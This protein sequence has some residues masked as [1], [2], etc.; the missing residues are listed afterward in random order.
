MNYSNV[1]LKDKGD[2][3][4]EVLSLFPK[5]NVLGTYEKPLLDKSKI[6]ILSVKYSKIGLKTL[7]DYPNLKTIITRSHGVDNINRDLTQKRNIKI[8]KTNP[9]TNNC[10]NWILDKIN[11]KKIVVFG[12]GSISKKLQKEIECDVIDSKTSEKKIENLLSKTDCIISTL[13]QN[14]TTKEYFDLRLVELIK[15]PIQFISI[16]RNTTISKG[17]VEELKKKKR[18]KEIYLDTEHIAW[19]YGGFNYDKK[20]G[21]SLKKYIDGEI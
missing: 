14:E 21:I 6:E 19:K 20:Y 7:N 4:V 15:N 16:S 2:L 11:G 9:S 13:P 3:S 8:I 10:S 1:L 17:F 12:N 18:L 5:V